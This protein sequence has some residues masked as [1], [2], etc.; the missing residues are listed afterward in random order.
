M[1]D[2]SERSIKAIADI[3]VG[4]HLCQIYE[5]E[6]EHR[7]VMTSFLRRGLLRN[8]KILY[9]VDTH[10]AETI[11]D[12]L[13]QEKVRTKP[14][15]DSGQ[16]LILTR[17]ESYLKDGVFV[18]EQVISMLRSETE[19]A[20]KDGF[21]ALR[22]TG[23]MSWA[24]RGLPGS[25]RLI[26]YESMLNDFFPESK[27]LAICQY[28]QTKFEPEI[29]INVIRAH[30]RIV[31]GTEV[32][33]NFYYIPPKEWS[34][35]SSSKEKFERWKQNLLEHKHHIDECHNV[36]STSI[37]GF[38]ALDLQCNFL[39]VN[40]AYCEAVGYERKDLLRLKIQ[41]IEVMEDEAAIKQ[42]IERI[43]I[44]GGDRFET[45][46][47]CRDGHIIDVEVS[48]SC[49]KERNRLYVFVRDITERKRIERDLQTNE[50]KFKAIT[51]AMKNALIMLDDDGKI[52]FWNHAAESIFGYM[53][54]EVLGKDCHMLLA[55]KRYH[56]AYHKAYPEFRRTGSGAAIGKDVRMEAVRKDGT[57]FPM[58]LS[59]SS[60]KV[61]DKWNAV[62]I[63]RDISVQK[64]LEEDLQLAYTELEKKV[65]ERTQ[66]LDEKL[67]E[68]ERF[69]KATVDR[70]FR[71][72]ELRD[73]IARLRTRAK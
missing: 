40:D 54:N 12:Y 25:E 57:E 49:I 27:A 32:C 50:N 59:L 65:S 19:K 42:H 68:L 73:E 24:L 5:T 70:E 15:I 63:I 55:P 8:E 41:D 47:R 17:D 11:L 20:I 46:H 51:G 21:S 3:K 34:G 39:N 60:V 1:F 66:E 61:G 53:T 37:D 71:M 62:G 23:E 9:I 36:I 7:L 13:E 45:R 16:L 64:G 58:E 67:K 30:P 26:E 52:K 38:L 35:K 6:D 69:R 29:L 28:D 43:V 72:K 44:T 4:Q 56:E 2:A 33:D 48:V 18:P 10:N 22:I 31:I 14:F